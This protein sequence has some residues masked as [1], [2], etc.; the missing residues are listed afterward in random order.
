[1]TCYE[2]KGFIRHL[3]GVNITPHTRGGGE[4]SVNDER[5]VYQPEIQ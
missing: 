3:E 2:I 4:R 5:A 1:M